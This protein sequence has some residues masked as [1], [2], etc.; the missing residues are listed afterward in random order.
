MHYAL[1]DAQLGVWRLEMCW[2]CGWLTSRDAVERAFL[3]IHI[4]LRSNWE[5]IYCY[6]L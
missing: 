2:G 6:V 1:W 3:G 5:G 4:A